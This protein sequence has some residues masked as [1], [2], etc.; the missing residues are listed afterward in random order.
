VLCDPR[1]SLLSK[2]WPALE[3]QVRAQFGAW[4]AQRRPAEIISLAA[5]ADNVIEMPSPAIPALLRRLPSNFEA[6]QPRYFDRGSMSAVGTQPAMG[7][8]RHEGGIDSRALGSAV[9]VG[10]QLLAKFRLA[11]DWDEARVKLAESAGRISAQIRGSGVNREQ[12][13][14]IAA[15]ALDIAAQASLD[16]TGAWILSPHPHAETEVRWTG[17]VAGGMRTVQADRVFRAGNTPLSQ[18]GDVWWIVDYK[19]AQWND[20]PKDALPKLRQLFAPQLELYASVLRKLHSPE[21]PIRA[22]L[23]YPRMLQFDW[24]EA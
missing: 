2:A 20:S 9:H 21:T 22:G 4:K 15:Q 8:Q 7:Y 11:F 17:I 24:W 14:K 13:A 6:P 10:L 12:A 23:F 5:S 18:Q 19:T 16:P 1:E 3:D